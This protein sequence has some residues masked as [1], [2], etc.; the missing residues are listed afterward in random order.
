V[1]VGAEVLLPATPAAAWLVL[2]DWERQPE[3]MVDAVSVRVVSAQRE[4]AGVRIAV[5]TRILGLAVLTDTLEVTGWDA[6]RELTM[7]RRGVVRGTGRWRL[8]A[9]PGGTRFEWTEEIRMPIPVLGELLLRLYRPVMRR[10]MRRSLGN[11][12]ARLR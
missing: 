2:L 12:A 7:V 8:E 5:R 11:L 10:L 4:G 1:K 9:R 6:P 3:W